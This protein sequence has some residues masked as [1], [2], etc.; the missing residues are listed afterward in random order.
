[1]PSYRPAFIHRDFHPGNVLWRRAA[2]SGIVDWANACVG[3][4]GC[5]VATCHGNLISW[6][7]REVADEF[8]AAYE[9]LVRKPNHPYWEIASVLEH[10]PSPWTPQCIAESER[11]LEHALAALGGS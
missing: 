8:T 9:A 6:A 4:T 5:D 3:P 11:R 1:M 7:G 10:G 2:C